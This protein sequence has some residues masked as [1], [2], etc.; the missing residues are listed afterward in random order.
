MDEKVKDNLETIDVGKS[1]KS[2]LE[3]DEN[4]GSKRLTEMQART[5]DLCNYLAL[6]SRGFDCEN[7]VASLERYIHDYGR[8]LYS[9]IT[10]WIFGLSDKNFDTMLTNLDRVINYT[11]G[12]LEQDDPIRKIAL[13]FYDHVNLARHQFVTFRAKEH[14]L[15]ALIEKKIEPELSKTTKE[16]TSQLVGLIGIFTAL[17]FIVFGGLD[18]LGG[19]FAN[20]ERVYS[21]LPTLIIILLWTFAM[22]NFLY[23]FMYFVMRIV[24]CLPNTQSK[25]FVQAHPLICLSNGI[26]ISALLVCSAAFYANKHGIGEPIFIFAKNHSLFAFMAGLAAII[27]ALWKMW[28]FL[29]RKYSEKNSD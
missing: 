5:V 17:S 2:S 29:H 26:L 28:S 24:K 6:S 12:H 27:F 16:L 22:M 15:E 7:W 1:D 11:V 13:K 14:D 23:A 8:L 21:I 18:T 19:I 25:N 9:N 3:P 4:L 20:A 10:N